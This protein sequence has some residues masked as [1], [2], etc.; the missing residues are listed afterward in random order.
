MC[1]VLSLKTNYHEHKVFRILVALT[2]HFKVIN[3]ECKKLYRKLERTS[4]KQISP[5]AHRSFNE[6]CLNIYIYIYQYFLSWN[7][8]EKNL[9]GHVGTRYI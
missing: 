8:I 4:I 7:I 5:R 3:Q 9:S 6:T 1:H 2:C